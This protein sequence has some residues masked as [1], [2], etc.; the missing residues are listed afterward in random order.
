M[1]DTHF[2]AT[3]NDNK[4]FHG[5]CVTSHILSKCYWLRFIIKTLLEQKVQSMKYS[6][7]I[8]FEGL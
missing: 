5:D 6:A 1:T 3:S 4:I 7:C 2:T 8:K